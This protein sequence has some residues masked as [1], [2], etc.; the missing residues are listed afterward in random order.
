MSI[1]PLT[2]DGARADVSTVRAPSF[3]SETFADHLAAA[4]AGDERALERLIT[5]LL[6]RLDGYLRSQAR[7]DAQDLRS[8][9]LLAIVHRLPRFQGD[10]TQFRSWVFTIAHHRLVDHRRRF[11]RT[12][13][14]DEVNEERSAGTCPSTEAT[15][16]ARIH[17]AELRATLDV[18]PEAQRR[19]LLLRTVGD[20]SLEQTAEVVGRSVGAV[21]LLQHRAVRT[22]REHLTGKDR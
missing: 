7:D 18:L 3:A 16:L 1:S 13:P 14:L 19:V 17:E 10:E 9:V 12:E 5:P 2:S 20:L 15:A 6:A 8:E 22:L 4:V 11:R 21:K